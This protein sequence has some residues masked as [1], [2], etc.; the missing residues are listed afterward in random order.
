[1][2]HLKLIGIIIKVTSNK[3][4]IN[5][6]LPSTTTGINN[7][8][9]SKILIK[10]LL[11]MDEQMTRKITEMPYDEDINEIKTC[12]PFYYNKI[13][14]VIVK[15]DMPKQLEEV[16]GLTALSASNLYGRM[17]KINSTSQIYNF[18][19]QINQSKSIRG[20][21]LKLNSIQSISS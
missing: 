10:K 14:N 9:E 2:K 20:W 17:V 11:E 4:Y 7:S 16:R 8:K 15:L 1:M 3:I 19:D 18:L 6:T 5:T 12:K 13:K 21:K